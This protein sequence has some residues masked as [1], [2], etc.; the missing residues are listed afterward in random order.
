MSAPDLSYREQRDKLADRIRAHKEFAN[1]DVADWIDDFLARRKRRHVLDLGCGDGNHL[2]LYLKHVT[3]GARSPGSTARR[4]CSSARARPV[5]APRT[6]RWSPAPWTT[7]CLFRTRPSTSAS[8]TS[9]S[10]TRPCPPFTLRELRRVLQPGGELVLIGP[11]RNNAFE[12]YEYNARLT[13]TAIDE[14]TLVRTDRLRSEIL[15][16]AREVF[17]D[18]REDVLHSRLTFPSPGE[19]LRYFTATML[20]EQVAEKMQCSDAAMLAALEGSDLVVS[21]EMLALVATR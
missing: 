8:R 4:S 2:G 7:P 1:F 20:Y 13:G 17:G 9:P 14:I 12:L 6:S 5:P 18:V 3:P 21:K 15:P 16:A 19:F 10:T 11:T